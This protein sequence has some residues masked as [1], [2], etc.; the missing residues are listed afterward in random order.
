M[1]G[2]EGFK[3]PFMLRLVVFVDESAESSSPGDPRVA[4]TGILARKAQYERSHPTVVGGR[5][6]ARPGCAR[7]QRTS[8]R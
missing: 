8:S 3:T 7:P 6:A 4:P 2:P 1:L 5:P